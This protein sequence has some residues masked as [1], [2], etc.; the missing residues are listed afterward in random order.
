MASTEAY[1]QGWRAGMWGTGLVKD[2]PTNPYTVDS[3]EYLNWESG[4]YD[5]LLDWD[6]NMNDGG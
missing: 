6:M 1:E 3:T 5:G 4:Y 2:K